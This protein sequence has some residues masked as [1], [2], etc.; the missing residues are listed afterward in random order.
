MK[1]FEASAELL[2]PTK[3]STFEVFS[4]ISERIIFNLLKGL[5][6][7]LGNVSHAEVLLEGKQF[8]AIDVV[9]IVTNFLT[10]TPKRS[11]VR[12]Y[13]LLMYLYQRHSMKQFYYTPS[14]SL[15]AIFEY[16]R[17]GT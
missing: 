3:V 5:S 10:L 16:L 2:S 8:E 13:R 6:K 7:P 12:F 15:L 14:I 9:D 4:R 17:A 11:N 1:E